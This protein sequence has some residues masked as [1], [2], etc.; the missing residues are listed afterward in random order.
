LILS[1]FSIYS[2]KY[3]LDQSTTVSFHHIPIT[4][5]Q[6]KSFKILLTLFNIKTGLDRQ[7][8]IEIELRMLFYDC[9]YKYT[10]LL[11]NENI[12]IILPNNFWIK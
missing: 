7:M 1:F 2:N 8:F 4:M 10:S 9:Q 12:L 5:Y 11:L 3:L 6:L